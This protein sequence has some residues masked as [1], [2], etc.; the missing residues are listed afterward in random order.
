MYYLWLCISGWVWSCWGCCAR[1]SASGI[2]CISVTEYRCCSVSCTRS[3]W[4]C[5]GAR[6]GFSCS[7][8]RIPTPALRS[9]RGA[10]C[11]SCCAS[12]TGEYLS[13]V[14]SSFEGFNCTLSHANFYFQR[15]SVRVWSLHNRN[16]FQCQRSRQDTQT[17]CVGGGEPSRDGGEHHQSAD[18]WGCTGKYRNSLLIIIM[19]QLDNMQ[20][21]IDHIDLCLS[22]CPSGI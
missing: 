6:C 15:T 14:R 11:N 16:T 12:Y 20:G 7:C 8:V 5:C 21:L 3:M 4:S 19:I 13:A 1:C 18:R 2:R 10:A 17:A 22:V 9:G